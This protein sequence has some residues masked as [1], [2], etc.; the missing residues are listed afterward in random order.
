MIS[1][2]FVHTSLFCPIQ[3]HNGKKPLREVDG[4]NAW[5]YDDLAS[6]PTVWSHAGKN[7]ESLGEL[8]IGLLRFYTEEF[9]YKDFVI[10]IRQKELLTRF[11]KLWN[12]KCLAIEDPFDLSHNLGGGL[13]RKMDNYIMKAF[14]NGR[15]L[16]GRSVL[17][18]PRGYSTLEDYLFDPKL[19]TETAPPNDRNCRIC[20]KIGHWAKECPTVKSRKDKHVEE[21][22]SGKENKVVSSANGGSKTDKNGGKSAQ[23]KEPVIVSKKGNAQIQEAK[24]A[25]SRGGNS[26][27]KKSFAKERTSSENDSQPKATAKKNTAKDRKDGQKGS[28]GNGHAG[29]DGGKT[30]QDRQQMNGKTKQS[31][32][33]NSELAFVFHILN[34]FE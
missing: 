15:A 31:E 9:S 29:K 26:S 10:S 11:E 6:V 23:N 22:K 8:W 25:M 1:H 12:G 5:F 19:L 13:S 2:S 17:E 32:K 4:W 24:A 27:E 7:K 20:N 16:F 34:S 28:E 33:S 3:L 30:R 18:V 14:Y 21:G